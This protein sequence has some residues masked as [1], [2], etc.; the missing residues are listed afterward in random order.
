VDVLEGL[1]F[2]KGTNS[3]HARDLPIQE[4]VLVRTMHGRRGSS[5]PEAPEGYRNDQPSRSDREVL[6]E[7]RAD[8]IQEFESFGPT[9][10]FL[11]ESLTAAASPGSVGVPRTKGHLIASG[12]EPRRI[13]WP[14][15]RFR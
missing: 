6:T 5:M 10:F 15:S 1:T 11:R 2:L 9:A 13:P 3:D 8:E 4:S 12:R 14:S 7:E